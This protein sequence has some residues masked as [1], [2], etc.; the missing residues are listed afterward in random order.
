MIEIMVVIALI[1]FLYSIAIPQFALRTGSEAATKIQRLADDLRSAFDLAALNNKTFRMSFVFS[2]GEYW[3][4]YADREVSEL[5][6]GKGGKDP[7]AAEEKAMGEAFDL[8]T[9]EYKTMAGEIT[10]DEEG[11]PIKGSTDSPI[12]KNRAAAKGPVWSRVEGLEWTD[13]TLGPY[14]MISEMQ[15]EHHTQKQLLAD[16][17]ASGG[18]YIY[19]FPSGYIEKAYI[20]V[21][22]KKDDMVVDDSQK[23]YTIITRPFL[24]TTSVISGTEEV[25]VHDL[26]E[27]S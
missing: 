6:D 18:A 20:T 1:A 4:E 24:G 11:E 7:S 26:K 16:V 22:F 2:T 10:R 5:G 13:R 23:P 12:L 19:F 8:Q 27:E 3:L 14:L 15:A 21:S 9:A 17:G 25:D